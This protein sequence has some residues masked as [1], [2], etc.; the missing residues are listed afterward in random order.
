M[1]V[2][3]KYRS[4][5]DDVRIKLQTA[6][7]E[8]LVKIALQCEGYTKRNIS[9]NGQIDT[10]FMLN[11]VFSLTSDGSSYN[12]SSMDGKTAV[13]PP[14]LDDDTAIV[15]VAANYAIHNEV[16]NS[17]LYRAAEQVAGEAGGI[18]Q[19]VFGD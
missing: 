18:V 8:S 19:G 1:S 13:P 11:S 15:G 17:F 7:R 5:G 3:V 16:R 2:D 4:L 6:V 9:D 10:G 14:A 12:P